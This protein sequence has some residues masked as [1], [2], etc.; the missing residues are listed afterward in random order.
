MKSKIL[1]LVLV[2]FLILAVFLTGCCLFK[3]LSADVVITK[4]EQDYS[5]GKWSDQVK[6][7]YTIT[8]TGS[9]D[10]GYYN[11]WLA[12][13]CDYE[14]IYEDGGVYEDWT[15]TGGYI[16]VGKSKDC[17]C[18]TTVGENEKVLGMNVSNLILVRGPLQ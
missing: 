6:V 15:I 2:I 10:I 13:Y 9:V 5:N 12:V 11:I 4:W 1:L 17:T 8:N 3:N 16:R 18:L 14:G 7:Y